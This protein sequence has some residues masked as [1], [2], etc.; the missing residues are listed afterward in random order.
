MTMER[1]D[2][3]IEAEVEAARAEAA[4]IGGVAGDEDLDP[5]ER[6][7]LEAGGGV[8]EGFEQAEE[9]LVEHASHGDQYSGRAA[10]H[11][12]FPSEEA[13]VTAEDAE[14]DELHTS[15]LEPGAE[16]RR[17]ADGDAA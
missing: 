9:A 15:E 7:V 14:A 10:L 8:A 11:D 3:D 17:G 1:N 2:P 16:E 4:A 13:G 12:A 6:P 5:A